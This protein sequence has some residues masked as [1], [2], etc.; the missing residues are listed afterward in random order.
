M[1][2]AIV[3]PALKLEPHPL[4]TCREGGS[5]PHLGG[6]PPSGSDTCLPLSSG[7]GSTVPCMQLVFKMLLSGAPGWLSG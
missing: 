5:M 4:G 1:V 2:R 7:G 3:L 6:S